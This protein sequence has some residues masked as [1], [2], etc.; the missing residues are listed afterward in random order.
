MIR[1]V[2]IGVHGSRWSTAA[3]ETGL[4]WAAD[5]KIPVTCLGIV[6]ES[7]LAPAEPVPLGASGYKADRDAKLVAEGRAQ[8]D[9][10]LADAAKRAGERSVECHTLLRNGSTSALIGE[11]A[12]RHDLVLLGRRATPHT[13][14]EPKSSQTLTEIVKFSPRPV[15]VCSQTVP[16]SSNVVI[17][18]DGSVQ[19]ARTLQSFVSSGLY[20]GHPLHL[21][22]VSDSPEAMQV[23]LSRAVDYLAAHSQSAETHVL[24]TGGDIAG[25]LVEFARRLPA[26]LMV[27][28]VYGQAWY[29]EL[30]FGSVT[31]RILA[32]VPVPLFLN[33]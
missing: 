2:L 33:H 32:E 20:Y 3:L 11:E 16:S 30:L 13:D 26:G 29:R 25:A 17:C 31:R 15:V 12:Q 9:T 21:V 4:T 5:W 7:V 18:Y 28:G 23:V 6:D 22:G 14:R 1:S 27:L 10:A 24:P 19:A 8:V